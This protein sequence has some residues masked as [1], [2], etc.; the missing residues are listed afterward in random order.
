VESFER[1]SRKRLAKGFSLEEAA[2]A[3]ATSKRT[4]A[5]RMHQA[6]GKSPLSYFQD[7]RIEC[8]VHLLKTTDQGVDEIASKIGY[9]DAV[10]LRVLLRRRLGCGVRE[11]RPRQQ[12]LPE[13]RS[14]DVTSGSSKVKSFKPR[15]ER[16]GLR[17]A[18]G[19]SKRSAV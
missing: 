18:S 13:L 7:L 4:L 2:R 15:L 17:R 9:A 10:T 8:A 19:I 1:W 5:R 16:T 6:L 12:Q 14:N 3:T 11:L